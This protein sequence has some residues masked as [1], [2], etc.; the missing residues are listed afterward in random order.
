MIFSTRLRRLVISYPAKHV[1]PG[2]PTYINVV[3]HKLDPV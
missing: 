1:P 2:K 3:L